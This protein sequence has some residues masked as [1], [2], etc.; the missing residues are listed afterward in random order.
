MRK[1]LI[2]LLWLGYMCCVCGLLCGQLPKPSKSVR[3]LV[4]D[5]F[6][7]YGAIR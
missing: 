1:R 4:Y 2:V 6:R 7:H 5:M 3:G